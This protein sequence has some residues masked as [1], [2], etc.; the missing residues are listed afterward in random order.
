MFTKIESNLIANCI[1]HTKCFNK[2]IRVPFKKQFFSWILS[3]YY[4]YTPSV[5]LGHKS[6]KVLTSCGD[7]K[8]VYTT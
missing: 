3:H 6:Q 5:C 8:R 2:I 4:N 1:D 7:L